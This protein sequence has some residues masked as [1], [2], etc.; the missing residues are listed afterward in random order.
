MNKILL[1]VL[2]I[3]LSFK[4]W[5]S[6]NRVTKVYTCGKDVGILVENIGWVVALDS[7]AG[8]KTVDRIYSMA[9]S[10][11]ATQAPISFTNAGVREPIKWCGIPEAKPITVMQATRN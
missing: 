6:E 8:E 5:S 2:L 4:V 10:L 1:A 9:L 3:S 7:Q 11:L